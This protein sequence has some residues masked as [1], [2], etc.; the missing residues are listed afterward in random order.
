[1]EICS[2]AIDKCREAT[3]REPKAAGINFCLNHRPC[4][5][6]SCTRYPKKNSDFCVLHLCEMP[7]CEKSISGTAG[8]NGTSAPIRRCTKHLVCEK[9][10]CNQFVLD[11]GAF[12]I[13]HGCDMPNCDL[14]GCTNSCAP[15]YRCAK[16]RI[17]KKDDCQS[18]VRKG[19]IF[20]EAHGCEKPGCE[21]V[22]HGRSGIPRCAKHHDCM[23]T[24][25]SENAVE[26]RFRCEK[27]EFRFKFR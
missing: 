15:M 24:K 20:C 12:C 13:I 4:S 1:M 21:G 23:T 11:G 6:P 17:C 3:C 19:R 14:V 7:R 18:V 8:H 5:T 26:G 22:R 16:H 27:R 9:D 10:G 25:C 2:L